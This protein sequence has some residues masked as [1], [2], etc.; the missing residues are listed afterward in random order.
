M[1]C[2]YIVYFIFDEVTNMKRLGKQYW[3]TYWVLADLG[4]IILV[5][6]IFL[7]GWSFFY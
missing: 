1:F 2:L 6:I 4:L 7:W 3:K 5:S